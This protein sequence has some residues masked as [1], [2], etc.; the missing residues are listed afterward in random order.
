METIRTE[1]SLVRFGEKYKSHCPIL[2][3]YRSYK[4]NTSEE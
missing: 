2:V 3:L 1:S 4:R